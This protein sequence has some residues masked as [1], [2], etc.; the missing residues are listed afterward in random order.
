MPRDGG[1]MS[2][3]G[4]VKGGD[5]PVLSE[6]ERKLA[7]QAQ[8]A[9]EAGSYGECLSHLGRLRE[10]RPADHKVLHN[11][12]V[13]RYYYSGLTQTGDFVQSLSGLKTQLETSAGDGGEVEK[14]VLLFNLATVHFQ[15]QQ[16]AVATSIAERLLPRVDLFSDSFSRSVYFLL[17]DLY[18]LTS[19]TSKASW[20]I[21][22]I[23][24]YLLAQ[25]NSQLSNV[26]NKGDRSQ[27][28]D[29][30]RASNPLGDRELYRLC[31]LKFRLCLM[32][33]VAKNMCKREMTNMMSTS[34]GTSQGALFLKS[35]FEFNNQKYT[36]AAKLLCDCSQLSS[37]NAA[38]S[39]EL[40]LRRANASALGTSHA[41]QDDL[42][43]NNMACV[44][45]RMNRHHVA[46]FYCQQALYLNGEQLAKAATE[47]GV[48]CLATLDIYHR[49]RQLLY[50]TGVEL[51]FAGQ[52]EAA[53]ASLLDASKALYSSPLLWLRLAEA[54][55]AVH[56]R[57]T[58]AAGASASSGNGSAARR[59][60]QQ[61]QQ[62]RPSLIRAGVGNGAHHKLIVTSA[63]EHL[64]KRTETAAI[65][66]L[67]LE[68]ANLC[69][70]NS[71]LLL[72]QWS[73]TASRDSR[74]NPMASGSAASA[75]RG[76]NSLF[77]SHGHENGLDAGSNGLSSDGHARSSALDSCPPSTGQQRFPHH[78]VDAVPLRASVLLCSTYV[79]LC[80]GNFVVALHRAQDLLRMPSLPG[81][82]RCHGSLYA[83]E[84][85]VEL[86][87]VEEAI[88]VLSP[89]TLADMNAYQSAHQA[90]GS[91]NSAAHRTSGAYSSVHYNNLYPTSPSSLSAG[92]AYLYLNLASVHS[93]N[94]D[95]DR[96]KR[97]L[98]HAC[99]CL[100]AHELP[101]QAIHLA[102]FLELQSGNRAAALQI[103]KRHHVP[104]AMM[105]KQTGDAAMATKTTAT[106]GA[107]AG[108]GKRSRKS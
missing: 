17:C 12:A 55:I 98:Q 31:Q 53:F 29:R 10:L 43:Y 42:F 62:S 4:V 82:F 86:S 85:L 36:K 92:K 97:C 73:P 65:P 2:D 52:P 66:A 22:K 94:N 79:S 20:L 99:A 90:D 96:A 28:A 57:D 78:T 80:L 40:S 102:A 74:T 6:N 50:N 103:L 47:H 95:V 35:Q 63:A 16:F 51:L 87:R 25:N 64:G 26:N 27:H 18:L 24:Q 105:T 49:H 91:T 34:H 61:Q 81:M 84:A 39:D 83:A 104:P 75:A 21:S 58:H 1:A 15:L 76:Q 69:L 54:C 107:A 46:A 71:S 88:V 38:S 68:F 67:T 37:S 33:R 89:E 72:K 59:N 106:S 7:G 48:S 11:I 32:K 60:Q 100:P 13:A 101:Q 19:E 14:R 44:Y 9:F 41:Y 23:D 3:N 8:N 30:E 93:L 77:T 70:K 45:S 108:G 56:Q 5:G